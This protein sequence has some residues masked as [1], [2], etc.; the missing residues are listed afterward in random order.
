M[1]GDSYRLK[2]AAGALF[3]QKIEIGRQ[4]CSNREK[5]GKGIRPY[6]RIQ[7]HASL[8]D[9][10]LMESL[11][12][13]NTTRWV[14]RRKAAVVTAVLSGKMTIE[15]A[16]HIYQLSEEEFLSWKCALERHGL[17]GLRVTRIQ[18]YRRVPPARARA[19]R[20]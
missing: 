13:P 17:A 18:Q 9:K 1:N 8:A 3:E 5:M 11:P 2:P 10:P 6:K 7:G 14:A 15:E 4:N 19:P 12:P 16:C 20:R